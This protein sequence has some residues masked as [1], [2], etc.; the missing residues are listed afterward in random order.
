MRRARAGQTFGCSQKYPLEGSP[1]RLVLVV[2]GTDVTVN[3]P[4]TAQ[5]RFTNLLN[6]PGYSVNGATG[7]ARDYFTISS[8]GQFTPIFDVYGPYDLPNSMAAY[9]AETAGRHDTDPY[10]MVRHACA[11]AMA[12]GVNFADYDADGGGFV[13]NVF[14][15]YAGYNQAEGGDANSIWPH[16]SILVPSMPVGD[17]IFVLNYACSSELKNPWLGTRMC[18]IGTFCYEFGHILGLPDCLYCYFLPERICIF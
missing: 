7:S 16:R 3:S 18:N 15:Y 14:V 8:F 12:A 17:N 13:G 4:S 6:Q 1:R 2:N 5:E 9:G 10:S 11:A